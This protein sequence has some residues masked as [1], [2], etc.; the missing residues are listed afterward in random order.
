MSK[1]PDKYHSLTGFFFENTS[2]TAQ[3]GGGKFQK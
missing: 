2:S 3:G 1:K